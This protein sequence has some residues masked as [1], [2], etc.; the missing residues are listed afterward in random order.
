MKRTHFDLNLWFSQQSKNQLK[1]LIWT[2]G[3]LPIAWKLSKTWNQ[4]FSNKC[5]LR[6]KFLSK[7]PA[8][9]QSPETVSFTSLVPSGHST[10]WLHLGSGVA[11]W[12]IFLTTLYDIIFQW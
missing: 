3:S 11:D 12:V 9:W 4:Q 2:A 5:S 1:N 10:C 7:W 6:K 8:F